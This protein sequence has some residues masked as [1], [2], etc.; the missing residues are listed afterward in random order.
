ME[1]RATSYDTF[2]SRIKSAMKARG[3]DGTAEMARRISKRLGRPI[4]RATLCKWFKNSGKALRADVLHALADEVDY[5][6]R[7]LALGEGAP[8]RWVPLTDKSKELVDVFEN[9]SDNAR[10]ELTSYAYRLMRISGKRNLIAP[11]PP[12]PDDLT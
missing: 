11:Y 1:L 8:A 7:W 5:S 4:D 10:A 2:E 6:S 12:P 9:L 3:I